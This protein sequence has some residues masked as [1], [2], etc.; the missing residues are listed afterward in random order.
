L[1]I[2]EEAKEG[3]GRVKGGIRRPIEKE[4]ENKQSS[5]RCGNCP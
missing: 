5:G 1:C 2:S 4:A 3:I